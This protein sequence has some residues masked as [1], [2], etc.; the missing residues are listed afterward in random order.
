MGGGAVDHIFDIPVE[1]PTAVFK[2]RRD[3]WKFN[4]A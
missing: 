1:I 4:V 2:Y 3:R